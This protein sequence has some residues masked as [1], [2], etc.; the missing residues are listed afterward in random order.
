MSVHLDNA[1]TQKQDETKQESKNMKINNA[2]ITKDTT[3][4]IRGTTVFAKNYR[5]SV[6]IGS[7]AHMLKGDFLTVCS[8][9]GEP[10]YLKDLNKLDKLELAI[11]PDYV[12]FPCGYQPTKY[13]G[14]TTLTRAQ[15]TS[16][17]DFCVDDDDTR[18]YVNGVHMCGTRAEASDALT[19]CRA[20]LKG[21]EHEGVIVNRIALK[22]LLKVSDAPSFTF[23]AF[24]G[25]SRV[26]QA[27]FVMNI[28]H[29]AGQFPPPDSAFPKEIIRSGRLIWDANTDLEVAKADKNKVIH[30]NTLGITD[31]EAM[32]NAPNIKKCMKHGGSW[33]KMDNCNRPVQFDENDNDLVCLCV[34]SRR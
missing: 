12:D 3:I 1:K 21:T 10:K 6:A 22:V 9:I 23:L 16:L 19:L 7:N 20:N 34:P 32:Y 18:Y 15:L 27:G 8:V 33:F 14:E 24:E 13:L 31:V 5:Y 17:L 2:L 29:I 28:R 4:G 25:F 26:E 30:I 11:E